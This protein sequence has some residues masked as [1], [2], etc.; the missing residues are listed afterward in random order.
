MLP[1]PESVLIIVIRNTY[2]MSF[3]KDKLHLP[4]KGAISVFFSIKLFCKRTP[5]F[6]KQCKVRGCNEISVLSCN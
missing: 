5:G 4:W 6:K 1:N 2:K 3:H